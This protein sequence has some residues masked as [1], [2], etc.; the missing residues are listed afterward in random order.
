M[1]T[2]GLQG[3]S[4]DEIQKVWE[5]ADEV[6]GHDPDKY[7]M[8]VCG[9]LIFRH[10]YGKTSKMGWEIDHIKPKNKGGSDSIRNLQALHWKNN[11]AKGD[12]YPA[13]PSIYCVIP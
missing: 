10:S 11:R 8:D 5:K 2:F 4:D 3:F 7:R 12:T 6:I 13:K 1:S 9:A